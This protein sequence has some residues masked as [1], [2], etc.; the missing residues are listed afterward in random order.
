[1]NSIPLNIYITKIY[2]FILNEGENEEKDIKDY[3]KKEKN[4]YKV[5]NRRLGEMSNINF[6]ETCSSIE[7]IIEKSTD[8]PLML[9]DLF[10]EIKEGI[11]EGEL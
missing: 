6:I 1:M 3:L 2:Y 11:K 10:F 5:L 4:F 8:K 7:D 9:I